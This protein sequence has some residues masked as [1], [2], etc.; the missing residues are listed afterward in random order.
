MG[1]TAGHKT[2]AQ[3]LC[4][5]IWVLAKLQSFSIQISIP[6]RYR[7]LHNLCIPIWM[8]AIRPTEQPL[9]SDMNA[10]HLTWCTASVYRYKIL[11]VNFM[12]WD[13]AILMNVIWHNRAKQSLCTSSPDRCSWKNSSILA[14]LRPWQNK[15]PFNVINT[16][17][18]TVFNPKLNRGR[19]RF[20]IVM[21]TVALSRDIKRISR[22]T[23]GPV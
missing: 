23:D 3:P 20:A 2:S 14:L 17:I 6:N 7:P 13:N 9:Y 8:L 4:I 5:L 12:Y 16:K 19:P 15:P 10:N 21:F 1:A 22:P 18:N 11:V